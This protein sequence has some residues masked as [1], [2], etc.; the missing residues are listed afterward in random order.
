MRL[1]IASGI[2]LALTLALPIAAQDLLVS[3]KV[4]GFNFN[5]RAAANDRGDVLVTW[6]EGD[7]SDSEYSQIWGA[8]L[9]RTKAGFK[10]RKPRRLSDLGVYNVNARPVWSRRDR[11]FLVVWDTFGLT[12]TAGSIL[13]RITKKNGKPTGTVIVI[14]DDGNGNFAPVLVVPDD[15]SEPLQLMSSRVATARA[16]TGP[17][18]GLIEQNEDEI[19][20]V[21]WTLQLLSQ[22]P[23]EVGTF[24]EADTIVDVIESWFVAGI[25]P[26]DHDC[27]YL[28]VGE[29]TAPNTKL[30]IQLVRGGQVRAQIRLRDASATGAIYVPEDETVVVHG[31]DTRTG[32][33]FRWSAIMRC[34]FDVIGL[35]TFEELEQSD[36]SWTGDAALHATVAV[37]EAGNRQLAGEEWVYV[38]D[39]G[40][41]KVAAVEDNGLAGPRELLDTGEDTFIRALAPTVAGSVARVVGPEVLVLWTRPSGNESQEIRAYFFTPA[42]KKSEK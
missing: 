25:D 27:S 8:L 41:M 18:G 21:G 33:P 42:S 32:A 39:A 10:V 6:T 13:G 29:G 3:K 1:R 12:G 2:L 35:V 11:Q 24:Y 23:V 37:S 19:S 16:S 26:G 17:D 34:E 20:I 28:L 36:R 7:F 4:R 31:I 5:A 30:Y 40:V 14:V 22:A 38:D 9:K 15:K